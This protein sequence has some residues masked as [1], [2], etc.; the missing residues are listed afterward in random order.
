MPVVEVFRVFN[1]GELVQVGLSTEKV[2]RHCPASDGPSWSVVSS[3]EQ[4]S[5]ATGVVRTWPSGRD[6]VHWECSLC[7]RPHISDF[8]PHADGN[9]VLWFCEAGRGLCLVH[10]R[11]PEIEQGSASDP[12]T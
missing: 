8:E 5:E 6:R 10:W 3:A 2:R 9:P 7:G 4:V 1:R 12:A 11:L